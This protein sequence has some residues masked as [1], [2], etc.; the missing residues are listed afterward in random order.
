MITSTAPLH[1]TPK[2]SMST[3]AFICSNP[4]GASGVRKSGIPGGSNSNVKRV[5]H[6]SG[7]KSSGVRSGIKDRPMYSSSSQKGQFGGAYYPQEGRHI[8]FE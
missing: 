8:H 5:G 2:T 1:L 3:Y 4:M 6:A 7:V